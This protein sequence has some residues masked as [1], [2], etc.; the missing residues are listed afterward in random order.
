MKLL[1]HKN[2]M[3]ELTRDAG[4]PQGETG[5][6]INLIMVLMYGI[7]AHQKIVRDYIRKVGG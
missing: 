5:K 4:I 7:P 3:N 1:T 2:L 6:A